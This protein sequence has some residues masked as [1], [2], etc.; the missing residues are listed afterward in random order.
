M[1]TVYKYLIKHARTLGVSPYVLRRCIYFFLS[2]A[3]VTLSPTP[4]IHYYMGVL[5]SNV[6]FFARLSVTMMHYHTLSTHRSTTQLSC[7]R[8]NRSSTYRAP[9]PAPRLVALIVSGTLL[10]YGN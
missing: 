7:T 3:S 6:A 5:T 10:L 8:R 2:A 9:S 1:Y 4:M